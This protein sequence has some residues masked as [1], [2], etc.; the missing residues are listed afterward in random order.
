M[1]TVGYL[2]SGAL[3]N[4]AH[5]STGVADMF[6]ASVSVGAPVGSGVGGGGFANLQLSLSGRKLQVEGGTNHIL[7]EDGSFIIA[8]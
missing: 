1:A 2:G 6:S 4:F 5:T 7:A 8:E 3:S